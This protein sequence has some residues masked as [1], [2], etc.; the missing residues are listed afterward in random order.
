MREMSP[1]EVNEILENDPDVLLL[2]VLP[3]DHYEKEHLPGAEN[4][5]YSA[6]SFAERVGPLSEDTG[7]P[8]IVYC[9]DEDCDLSPKAAEDLE[10]AGYAN[11][12]DMTAGIEGWKQAGLPVE[13]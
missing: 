4:V 7:Q 10:K 2:D 8:V 3:S 13:S 12:I 9:A 6:G 5:P 1:Q 11:V